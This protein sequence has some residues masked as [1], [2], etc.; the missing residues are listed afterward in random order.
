M[1]TGRPEG[2]SATQIMLHWSIATLVIFQFFLN[3]G[4]E[5]AWQAY[6]GGRTA[7]EEQLAGAN[8]HVII[9]LVILA[10]AIWRIAIRLTRGAPPPPDNEP[11]LMRRAASA[12]HIALYVLII[13]VPLSG[14]AAWFLGAE[15]ASRGH[16]IMRTLLFI[17]ACL[18][19]AGALVQLLVFRSNV[20]T[21]M[22][23]TKD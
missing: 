20:F 9:G 23:M 4:I 1:D 15:A 13:L 7:S 17:L 14:A 12:T 8:V 18:H 19:I 21:R 3:D 10:L 16:G 6:A 11:T 5:D 2:Y 22:L